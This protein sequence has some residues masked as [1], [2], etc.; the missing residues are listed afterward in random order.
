ME[1]LIVFTI[2]GV[3]TKVRFSFLAAF[4]TVTAGIFSSST[5]CFAGQ[6]NAVL[7]I[8]D[9]APKWKGLTGTDDRQHAAS[10]VADAKCTLIVF[11]C[12]TCPYAVDVEDRLIALAEKF[13]VP[14]LKIVAINSNVGEVDSLEAMKRRAL[15]KKFPFPYVRD[16]SQEVAKQFGATR[17]PEFFVID[18][19]GKLFYM[20][21]LDDSPDG[22]EV[23][24]QYVADAIEAVVQGKDIHVRE[25]IPVGCLIRF[26]RSRRGR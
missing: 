15:D 25:T 1:R 17:T 3:W 8:G 23:Q 26:A 7:S 12:N 6:Y 11:T 14:K 19:Q 4:V 16:D 22:R 2:V 9:K 20:G 18:S 13:P 24:E 10:D 5:P 21:A